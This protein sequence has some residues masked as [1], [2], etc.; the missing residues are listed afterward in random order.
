MYRSIFVHL[1]NNPINAAL[2]TNLLIRLYKSYL[3]VYLLTHM[4]FNVL[5]FVSHNIFA[6]AHFDSHMKTG[7]GYRMPCS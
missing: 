3:I 2:T 7:G 1:S 4:H 5:S 6:R